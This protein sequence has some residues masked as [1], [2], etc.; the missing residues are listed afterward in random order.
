MLIARFSI[1]APLK[2]ANAVRNYSPCFHKFNLL[3]DEQY[4]LRRRNKQIQNEL[5]SIFEG[6]PVN[7]EKINSFLDQYLQN[8]DSIDIMTLLQKLKDHKLSIHENRLIKVFHTLRDIPEELSADNI[9]NLVRFPSKLH[10]SNLK[11]EMWTVIL[12]K[13]VIF[14]YH[15]HL[16]IIFC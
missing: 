15:T 8:M 5:L 9:H 13:V 16:T 12:P 3:Q 1:H 4:L 10:N 2:F 6:R 7:E 14:F 11:T